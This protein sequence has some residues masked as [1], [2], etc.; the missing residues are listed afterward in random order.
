MCPISNEE[1]TTPWTKFSSLLW[2]QIV[3]KWTLI[4]CFSFAS[5]NELLCVSNVPFFLQ[6][7]II[8]GHFTTVP[9][10]AF[11]GTGTVTIHGNPHT[12]KGAK[13][14]LCIHT[15]IN[16]RYFGTIASTLSWFPLLR[17]DKIPGLFQYFF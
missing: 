6:T 7:V 10:T 1:D 2:L 14:V 12:Y 17:T 9:S 5:S 15:N 11:A 4:E 3:H 13:Q 8:N 16:L